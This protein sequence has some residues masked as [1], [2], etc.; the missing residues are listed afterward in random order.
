MIK[1]ENKKPH[2]VMIY[3]RFDMGGLETLIVRASNY[4]LNNGLAV[5]LFIR[6][7]AMEAALDKGVEVIHFEKYREIFSH[8]ALL[9]QRSVLISFDP[10][11]YMVMRRL[12]FYAYVRSGD[13]LFGHGGVFHP[14]QFYWDTDPLLVRMLVKWIFL[15]SSKELW[16]F[17]SEAVRDATRSGL[18]IKQRLDNAVIPLPVSAISAVTWKPLGQAAIKIV[19]VG[20]L[21]PAKNY[22]RAIPRIVIE[23]VA[24][25]VDVS[26]DIW[27][28]GEDLQLIAEQISHHQISKRVCLRGVL[29]YAD[30]KSKLEKYDLFV[31]LGTAALEAASIGMPTICAV[32]SYTDICY[33]FLYEAPGDCIG[34][35]TEGWEYKTTV[36]C[37]LECSQLSQRE[38]QEIG[39][40]C[41]KGVGNKSDEEGYGRMLS[42]PRWLGVSCWKELLSIILAMPYLWFVDARRLRN[43]YV[44]ARNWLRGFKV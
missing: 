20:R 8:G 2:V 35:A 9:S 32:D 3:H 24:R 10:L 43:I 17:M 19:S 23:L 30:L 26:W 6:P 38:R 44:G 27:G 39:I 34:E 41:Q 40:K 22:N 33:G 31:G 29:P 18:K 37:I 4:Y 7:G 1:V 36:A 25:G 13:R 5:T 11:S 15:L 16:F 12:Q 21:V 14:R 42:A 28:D